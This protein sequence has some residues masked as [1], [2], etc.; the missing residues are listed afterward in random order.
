MVYGGFL[1]LLII[2]S[3][4][5]YADNLSQDISMIFFR[6]LMEMKNAQTQVC[7]KIV[8]CSYIKQNIKSF[9][10]KTNSMSL[11]MKIRHSRRIFA[12]GCSEMRISVNNTTIKIIMSVLLII[13]V[14]ISVY[15]CLPGKGSRQT[16]IFSDG[17]LSSIK[18]DDDS[19]KDDGQNVVVDMS[20][21]K[22]VIDSGHGGI[23][24]G[25]KS[26]S[27]ILEKDVNLAIA[28]KLKKKL[29]EAQISVTMT[30]NDENGLYQETD[31]NKKIADMKKRCSIIEESNAD[32]AVSIHQNSFQS[33]Q[34][35]GA[36]VFYYKHSASG[37]ELAECIQ[38]AFKEYADQ[39]NKRQAKADNTY[40]MLIHTKIPTV[41]AECGFLSN[42]SEAQLLVSEEYQEKVALALYNGITEYLINQP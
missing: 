6:K 39:D 28:F 16:G 10:G 13:C 7:I 19:Q 3:A 20:D 18:Q 41:I 24:P 21:K 2:I 40:Y 30:R 31:S 8:L 37:K 14:Y 17:I 25:K 22:V 34:V 12:T 23:D 32:V 11:H 38:K 33:S 9:A 26:E 29:E 4:L 5:F 36:Q 15:V 42:P 35:K 27:G 1:G